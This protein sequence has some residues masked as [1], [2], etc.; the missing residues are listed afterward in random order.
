MTGKKLFRLSSAS[1]LGLTTAFAG[2]SV[3][4]APAYNLRQLQGT[5]RRNAT[6]AVPS[7]MAPLPTTLQSPFLTDTTQ[8]ATPTR[9]IETAATTGPAL[10]IEPVVRLTLQEIVQRAVAANMDVRVAGYQPAIDQSRVVEQEAKFD[11]RFFTNAQVQYQ[12]A[13][14][15]NTINS[16]FNSGRWTRIESD[17]DT[18][19]TGF[20]Q[21]L[22]SGG[23][24][25]I[26]YQSVYTNSDPASTVMNPYFTNQLVLQVN[27]PLLRNFGVT[28]NRA[29]IVVNRN[30]QRI[31][32][33][34]FRKTL[35]DTIAT[36]EKTYWQLVAAQQNVAIQVRLLDRHRGTALLL[37]RRLTQ[38]VQR[39][40]VSQ[41]NAA[42]GT[43]QDV[44]I[45]AKADVRNLSDQ[46]KQ[47]MN[48]P[49]FPVSAPTLILPDT[50][51]VETPVHFDIA[52]L[53]ASAM[54]HR[55]DL[56]EQQLKIDNQSTIVGVARNN[57]LPR[58]DLIT[59]F[60]Y[61]GLSDFWS[62]A[63][64]SQWAFNQ[65]VWSVQL[66]FE[67]PI[68]NREARAIY[69]RT[70]LQRQQAIDQYRSLVDKASLEI[71]QSLREVQTAWQQMVATREAR[72]AQADSLRALQLRQEANEPLTPTFVQLLL[73]TQTRLAQAEQAEANAL[74]SYNNALAVLE[75]SKGTLLRY[76]S[77]IMAEQNLPYATQL[78][79]QQQETRPPRP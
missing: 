41:A 23:Q 7:A 66:Q 8:G 32:L 49:S 52:D 61:Q 15:P 46:L 59:S 68:G 58:L 14:Q 35:E 2:C 55:F 30:N 26:R 9:P 21:N 4:D 45:R 74:Y 67:I 44:V 72:F 71:T 39:S 36:I 76:D 34:E 75:R 79:R 16:I 22:S 33:L 19:A 53:I 5:E 29:Q 18:V 63:W 12:D 48:D 31:S 62:G 69:Q 64:E 78:L 60:G 43:Q 57:L 17:V 20:R 56:A 77:V 73:D 50:Q 54:E 3:P 65:P 47:L 11:P 27:Q 42:Y 25:E 28:I 1:L 10:G 40:Q 24:T 38:D 13:S 37:S 51:P 6:Q 70:L